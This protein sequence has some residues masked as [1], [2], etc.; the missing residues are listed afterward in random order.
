MTEKFIVKPKAC[1]GETN[2]VTA[3]INKILIIYFDFKS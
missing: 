3:P 1:L 2:T